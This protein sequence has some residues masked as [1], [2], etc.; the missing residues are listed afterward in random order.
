MSQILKNGDNHKNAKLSFS[1]C[2]KDPA[3]RT[4][5]VD[6]YVKAMMIV[7]RRNMVNREMKVAIGEELQTL[8]H[9]IANS[10]KQAAEEEDAEELAPVKKVLED[11]AGT[12]KA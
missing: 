4:A 7:R 11:I 12:L 10:T 1:Y 3:E 8:S 5:L 9:P 6:E 2:F